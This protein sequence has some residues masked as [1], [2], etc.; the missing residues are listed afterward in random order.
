MSPLGLREYVIDTGVVL[1]WSVPS[2]EHSDDALRYLN[3]GV[4]LHAPELLLAEAT[5]VLWKKVSRKELTPDDAE[6]LAMDVMQSAITFHPMVKLILPALE[7]AIA[8]GRTGYDS[9]YLALARDLGV[10]MVTADR[11]LWNA[12]QGTRFE[13]LVVWVADPAHPALPAE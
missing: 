1:K 4:E 3:T 11:R 8:T 13:S 2:E 9:M 5:N 12:L 6:N 10:P 7:L